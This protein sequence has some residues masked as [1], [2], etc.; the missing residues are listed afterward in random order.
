MKLLVRMALMTLITAVII[1]TCYMMQ[2][3]IWACM[4]IM[5]GMHIIFHLLDLFIDKYLQQQD[6]VVV[7]A[8]VVKFLSVAFGDMNNDTQSN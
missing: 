1:W 5:W 6:K 3:G 8:K 4:L 2:W 7:P